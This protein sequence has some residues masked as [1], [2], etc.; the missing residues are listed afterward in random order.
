MIGFVVTSIESSILLELRKKVIDQIVS[1]VEMLVIS[2]EETCGWTW[3]EITAKH[4]F[5]FKR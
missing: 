2:N 3:V 5:A 4:L 1:L